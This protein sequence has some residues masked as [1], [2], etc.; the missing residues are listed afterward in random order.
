MAFLSLLFFLLDFSFN[1]LRFTAFL[2]LSCETFVGAF[3]ANTRIGIVC[4]ER[5]REMEVNFNGNGKKENVEIDRHI[6]KAVLFYFIFTIIPFHFKVKV[7]DQSYVVCF[8]SLRTMNIHRVVSM[9]SSGLMQNQE[10]IA[11]FSCHTRGR[12]VDTH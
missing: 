3:E 1:S 2:F 7:Q 5:E 11:V 9:S 10:A 6:H 8:P 4:R 12:A